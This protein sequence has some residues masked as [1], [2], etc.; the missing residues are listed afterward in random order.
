MAGRFLNVF[1]L[2]RRIKRRGSRADPAQQPEEPE[3]S[4]PMQDGAAMD[5]TQ[6]QEPTGGLFPSTVQEETSTMGAGSMDNCD[7]HTTNTSAALLD[8]PVEGGLPSPK[9]VPAMVRYIHQWLMA[10][11]SHEHRLHR[12][13]LDLTEAQPTDVVMTLLH[14]APSCDRAAE[15]MW[16][17]IL[18]SS[19]TAVSVQLRL[20][21][22][23]GNWPEHS[24]CTSD[25]DTMRVFAL[26]ATV[27]MWKFLQMPC[28]PHVETLDFTRLFVHLLFQVLFS[29]LD[30]PEE[31]DKLWKECQ[32]QHG[33]AASPNRF[34]VQTLK[35]LLC[36]MQGERVV[37]AME[38]KCGWD[39][40]LC[41]DTHHYA[42]GLL[43]RVMRFSSIARCSGI[44]VY[45]LRLLSMEVPCWDLAALAFIVEVLE[46]L[47]VTK[48]G[49]S[50]LE[51]ISKNL[52]SEC[53]ERR[54]LALRGLVV[55]CPLNP[56]MVKR[57]QLLKPC[58]Q[59]EAGAKE[60]W[61]LTE[62]LVEL[63]QEND[64]D[65]V[66]M[67]V[68]VLRH[69]FLCHGAPLR[70]PIALRLA[71]ALL[72]LFDSDD[73]Q[74]QL[75]SMNI[76]QE[77]MELV[78]EEER[79]ALKSH[80][81]QSLFPLTFHCHDENPYVAEA[82]RETLHSSSRF[83]KRR[84]IEQMLQVDETWRFGEGLLAE[85]RSRAAEH[86]RQ[87][88]PYLR[89]P[90]EPLRDAAIRFIGMAGWCLRG[91]E[92]ELQIISEA[93]EDMA[94]DSSPAIRNLSAETAFILRA[95]Q[96]APY[97]SLRKLQDQIRRVCK[98]RPRLC[99]SAWLC[100]WSSAER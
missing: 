78:M 4:Q 89:S 10:N 48:Y 28:I 18:C 99:G 43:A 81:H 32:Q 80:V 70:S 64:S 1:K 14:V 35:S 3:P 83:L 45:L 39:M 36:R 21:D 15:T 67:S 73:S 76:F 68:V 12:T 30:M 40:L 22:V 19:R 46:C 33:L 27:V 91:Q 7:S 75:C 50:L 13:L 77:M 11:E 100:C 8:R 60:M 92:E 86:L 62:S 42:V 56:R 49:T 93:L 5:R 51:I 6:E 96:A 74:V 87:A 29:T 98:R 57:K 53:R 47:D 20:L 79:K 26:A 25:G 52:Q 2:F 65:V 37:M 41:A 84:D 66:R 82:S 90:Q 88:L 9:Q 44:A 31:V 55:L 72:P 69:L 71:E 17:T 97:S 95:V 38:H 61:S 63:L 54:H 16:K 94:D 85:D 34:A 23:L 58:Q 24:T 59:H